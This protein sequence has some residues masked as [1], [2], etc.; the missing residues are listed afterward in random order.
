MAYSVLRHCM[1]PSEYLDEIRL[2]CDAE[3]FLQFTTNDR[4]D[5][6]VRYLQYLVIAAST[7][8][9]TNQR[10]IFRCPVR[11]FV[12]NKSAG[13]NAFAFCPSHEET[14]RWRQRCAGFIVVS[15][16]HGNGRAV[17]DFVELRR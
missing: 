11:K 17:P 7:Q 1:R 12:V 8:K 2:S 15:K 13:Q 5:L 10:P 14:E 4:S 16:C 6:S 3:N 9:A